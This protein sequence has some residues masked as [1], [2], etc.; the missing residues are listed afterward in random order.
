MKK[1]REIYY[2]VFL[3]LSGKKCIVVGGGKVA[4][5]KVNMLLR[6]G[7]EIELISSR[8][9]AGLKDLAEKGRIK[10]LKRDYRDGDIEGSFMVIAATGN[11]RLNNEIV[12]EARDKKILVNVVDNP[13]KC[14]FIVPSSFSRG[15]IS[16]AVSTGGKSPALARSLRLRLEKQFGDEYEKLAEIVGGLRRELAQQ[17]IKL[18]GETWQEALDPERLAELLRHGRDNEASQILYNR[19][20]EMREKN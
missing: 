12:K 16:I 20:M 6:Y 19:L 10:L 14:D 11:H 15:D 17:G 3:N 5:R 1:D 8:I 18:S 9:T 2:P 7:I 13:A 4:L